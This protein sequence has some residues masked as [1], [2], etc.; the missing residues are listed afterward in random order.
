MK[1]LNK[2]KIILSPWTKPI[3]ALIINF[4]EHQSYF[5]VHNPQITSKKSHF[6]R[7]NMMI[8][9]FA[10]YNSGM[11]WSYITTNLPYAK[12][13][14]FLINTQIVGN[15]HYC[16]FFACQMS[17]DIHDKI[18]MS[19][20][21]KPRMGILCYLQIW[22]ICILMHFHFI[23]ISCASMIDYS[24]PNKIHFYGCRYI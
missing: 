10:C 13:F 2:W 19:N 16:L 5:Y 24:T 11:L 6:Q 4:Y 21:M 22:N 14:Q 1:A 7:K 18:S 20:S 15:Y 3:I 12:C 9:M 8:I 23:F 17:S